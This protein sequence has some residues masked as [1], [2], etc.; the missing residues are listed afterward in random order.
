MDIDGGTQT[1]QTNETV[2]EGNASNPSN[3]SNP[4]TVG[5][6]QIGFA[7]MDLSGDMRRSLERAGYE[8]PSPVQ[9][10]VI[11]PAL[12]GHEHLR[13]TVDSPSAPPRLGRAAQAHLRRRRP[14]VCALR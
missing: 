1:D 9:M 3:E 14:A 11:P 12:D 2:S 4:S 7:D 10:G 13:S 8:E 6:Q 5:E